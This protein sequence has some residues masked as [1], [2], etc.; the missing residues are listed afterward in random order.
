[1]RTDM[2]TMAKYKVA[3]VIGK[4][5]GG[6]LESVILD[7]LEGIDSNEFQIDL[8]IDA[9]STYVPY[10]RITKLNIRMYEVTPYQQVF[11]FVRDLDRIFKNQK[12]DIVHAHMSSLNVFPMFAAWINRVPIRIAHNHNLISPGD[13]KLKNVLKWLL[14]KVS[15][16]FPTDFAAPSIETGSWIYGRRPFEIIPN[17]VEVE[18]FRFN[19]ED[20]RKVREMLGVGPDEI[21]IGNFGRFVGVK[22]QRKYLEIINQLVSEGYSAKGLLV[23]DGPLKS[24][25]KQYVDSNNVLKKHIIFHDIVEDIEKYYA[26]IDYFLFTSTREAYG[27]VSVEAQLSGAIVVAGPGVPK[28]TDIGE[29][30]FYHHDDYNAENWINDIVTS[31]PL[32]SDVREITIEKLNDK[33]RFDRSTMSENFEKYYEKLL[34]RRV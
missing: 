27:L 4:M 5:V 2:A 18:K 28:M 8:I 30:I 21:L 31:V 7:A 24:E 19:Q 15:T 14:S 33:S 12:Y 32:T 23:G 16:I 17:G 26:A 22:N 6:G 13:G 25:L 29:G 10:D 1:M 20:R 34:S 3:F 11:G 9:D